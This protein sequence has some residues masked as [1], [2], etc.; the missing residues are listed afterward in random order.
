MYIPVLLHI[1]KH[2]LIITIKV[3]QLFKRHKV[4]IFIKDI[5]LANSFPNLKKWSVSH[6][7]IFN[8]YLQECINEYVA[9]IAIIP[10]YVLI[11]LSSIIVILW[12]ALFKQTR[13]S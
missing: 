6:H 2:R 4:Q 1:Y 9:L 7:Y 8:S 3:L 11:M 12:V 5:C 13:E 10:V